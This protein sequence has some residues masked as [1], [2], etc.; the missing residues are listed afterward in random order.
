MTHEKITAMT[1]IAAGLSLGAAHAEELSAQGVYTAECHDAEGNLVWRDT[2]KNV[3]TTLG[4]NDLLDKYLAGS[5]YTAAFYLGA[6]GAAGFVSAPV[7]A[8]T[9]ASHTGWTEAGALNAPTYSQAARPT[10]VWA[11]AASGSK[12][13]SASLSFGITSTGT[14]KGAFLSTSPTKDGT[15]GILFSAGLFTG[16]DQPVVNGNTVTIS[17][18]LGV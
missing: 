18:S 6:I 13:L 1:A 3:V 7:A 11:A 17:Y 5:A 14:L 8:D 12:A 4:K 16:G 9:A 10:A 15:T 2:I